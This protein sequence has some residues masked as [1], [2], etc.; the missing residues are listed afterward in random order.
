MPFSRPGAR[1]RSLILGIALAD[2]RDDFSG[3]RL[4]THIATELH[5]PEAIGG[6][7]LVDRRLDNLGR[8]T[9]GPYA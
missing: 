5:G 7:S 8:I 4:R 6:K 9:Q 2:K 3:N 1:R